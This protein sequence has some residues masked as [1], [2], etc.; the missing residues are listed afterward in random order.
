MVRQRAERTAE[1]RGDEPLTL[2]D[3]KALLRLYYAGLQLP[4][5]LGGVLLPLRVRQEADKS[6]SVLMECNSSSLRYVLPIPTA[7]RT[8]RRKVKDQQEEGADPTCPRHGS[9]MR[10]ARVG[11][12]LACPLCGVP[13]GKV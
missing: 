13:Y 7:T 8:E 1:P 10:L 3:T 12:D 2:S 6:A 4:S 11:K 9:G 5:P